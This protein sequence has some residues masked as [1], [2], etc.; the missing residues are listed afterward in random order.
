MARVEQLAGCDAF[1]SRWKRGVPSDDAGRFSAK[2]QR[3]RRQVLGGGPHDAAADFRGA[4]IKQM[5]E[6]QRGEGGAHF[7]TAEDCGDLLLR[8]KPAQK[9]RQKFGCAR[10]QFRWLQ[11][12]AIACRQR[13]DQRHESKLNRIVPGADDAHDANRLVEDARPPRQEFQA[14]PDAFRLHPARQ[15]FQG[16]A[17]RGHDRP[18]IGKRCLVPRAVAEIFRDDGGDALRFLFDRCAQPPDVILPLGKRS[19]GPARRKASRCLAR[20][21]AGFGP[22]SMSRASITLM[23]TLRFASGPERRHGPPLAL[24]T[25]VRAPFC[26][27][28][29]TVGVCLSTC[30]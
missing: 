6:G 7:R 25:G 3:H 24:L 16:F 28:P 21:S 12:D 20:I 30:P 29:A 11:H 8:E 19:G 14:D 23:T 1:R 5:I 9:V 18:D 17:R 2:F 15:M 27:H 10:R 13:R 4:G 26:M 22:A